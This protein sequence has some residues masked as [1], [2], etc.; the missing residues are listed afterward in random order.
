MAQNRVNHLSLGLTLAVVAGFAVTF[1]IAQAQF[2]PIK[3]GLGKPEDKK[4][5]KPEKPEK[6]AAPVAAGKEPG[7]LQKLIENLHK[8]GPNP[9]DPEAPDIGLAE[10]SRRADVKKLG[11][12]F[13]A[14]LVE[15]FNDL[16]ADLSGSGRPAVIGKFR[17]GPPIRPIE[18]R[19][20]LKKLFLS[21][22][23]EE[24]Q[25]YRRRALHVVVAELDELLRN[26]P[27]PANVTHHYYRTLF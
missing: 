3:P 22:K 27:K 16:H 15:S 8:I 26:P 10:A 20:R 7:S 4:S 13:V 18:Y 17:L 25:W 2:K 5:E 1:T 19:E 6:P 9:V 14:D 11:D 24:Y 21:A 12:Q 23:P